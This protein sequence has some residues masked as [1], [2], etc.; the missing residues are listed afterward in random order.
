M[1]KE[2]EKWVKWEAREERIRRQAQERG[3]KG[4]AYKEKEE[5]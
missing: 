5:Y 4:L 1:K 3:Y 2:G